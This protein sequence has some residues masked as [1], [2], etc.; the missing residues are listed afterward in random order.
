MTTPADT[1]KRA[2]EL[3]RR[4]WNDEAIVGDLVAH[5]MEDE[6]AEEYVRKGA[7]SLERARDEGKGLIRDE[8]WEMAFGMFPEPDEDAD[9]QEHRRKKSGIDPIRWQALYALAR[10]HLGYGE[11]HDVAQLREALRKAKSQARADRPKLLQGGK[12]G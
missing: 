2:R 4:Q 9:A 12:S 10:T 1:W 6:A 8:I 11:T 5:G 3:A 7:K